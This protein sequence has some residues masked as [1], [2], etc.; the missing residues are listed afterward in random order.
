MPLLEGKVLG[1]M[2][3]T[4]RNGSDSGLFCSTGEESGLA[5]HITATRWE[6]DRHCSCYRA[7]RDWDP[8]TKVRQSRAA[9]KTYSAKSFRLQPGR[10]N[11]NNS[12]H[13]DAKQTRLSTLNERRVEHQTARFGLD[14]PRRTGLGLRN[15]NACNELLESGCFAGCCW[16]AD[17]D[18]LK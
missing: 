15:Q 11:E 9:P 12:V 4:C 5:V 16:A 18:R 3:S 14:I 10:D 7:S 2:D 6:T 13:H 17:E 1:D 8:A